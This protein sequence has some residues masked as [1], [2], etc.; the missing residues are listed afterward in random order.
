MLAPKKAA[1]VKSGHSGQGLGRAVSREENIM[2]N[3]ATAD[4]FGLKQ[5]QDDVAPAE[6]E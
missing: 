5:G 3:E 4:N 1:K 2:R 6:N